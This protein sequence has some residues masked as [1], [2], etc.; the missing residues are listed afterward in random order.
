[1]IQTIAFDADDTLWHSETLY[2]MTQAEYY[3]LLCPY[4]DEETLKARLFEIEMRNL[5]VFGYGVKGFTLSMIETAIDI[6]EGRV[7]AR[8]TQAILDAGKALLT[9]PIEL[10]PGV[11]E[12]LEALAGK[13]NLMLITKGDLFHQESRIAASG[14]GDLF[15]ALEIVSEKDV[16]TYERVFRRYHL[17]PNTFLMVGNS[18]RSDILPIVAL[19][20]RAIYIPYEITWQHEVADPHGATH[21]GWWELASI[22]ELPAKLAELEAADR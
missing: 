6:S 5:R 8:E 16:P 9:R 12:T 7:T 17:D 18:V 11:R 2:A 13:Y 3:A 19:G 4:A 10:L 20:A 21:D 14:L 1:M 22:T 15:S